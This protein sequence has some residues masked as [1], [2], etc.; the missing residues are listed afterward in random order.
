MLYVRED[1]RDFN[2]LSFTAF[3]GTVNKYKA[4]ERTT[5]TVQGNKQ[6]D[7]LK[8]GVQTPASFLRV[9]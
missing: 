8:T 9:S 6:F 7:Q 3:K 1:L 5:K 2:G 4:R